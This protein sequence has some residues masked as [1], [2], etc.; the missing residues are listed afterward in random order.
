MKQNPLLSAWLAR[1][2]SWS[3][4]SSWEFSPDEW[5]NKYILNLPQVETPELVFGKA[6]ATSCENRTPVAPVTLLD[7]VEHPFEVP[8]G[9]LILIGYADTI[10]STFTTIGEYKTGVKAW[11]Q[12]RVDGHHQLTMYAL[13]NYLA[14]KIRPEDTAFFLEWIPTKRTPRNNNDLSG[15]DNDIE[16]AMN[17]PTIHHFNTRRTMGEILSFGARIK[18]DRALMHSYAL[19]RIAS[20]PT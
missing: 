20:M 3:Q 18:R 8:F 1:P 12:K 9:D 19:S 15:F 11:D 2:V 16:F 5:F 6:F 13:M 4:L 10:S 14:N 17:P 7:I